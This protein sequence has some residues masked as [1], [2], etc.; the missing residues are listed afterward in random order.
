ML[1]LRLMI[2]G[3]LLAVLLVVLGFAYI[4]WTIVDYGSGGEQNGADAALVLGAAA[5]GNKPSPVFRER[6]N[7]AV[8]LYQGGKVRWIVF[9]GGTPQ[10][11]YPSEADVGREFAARQ[12]VPMTAMLA[13]TE[14]R[15]TWQ[16]LS[17]ARDLGRQFGIRSYL[18]V[19]DPLHMRRAV[20]MAGDLG[21]SAYPAPTQSSRFRTLSSW[22]RF[23]ARETWLYLGYRVFRQ[24]S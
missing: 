6:I 21:L 5:W 1:Y 9:T 8:K 22:S 10:P 13:E 11:G 17:N 7:H 2:K 24:L 15:T 12:G 14:S 4:A 20:L 3:F 16:N 23:L 18:L 19:S